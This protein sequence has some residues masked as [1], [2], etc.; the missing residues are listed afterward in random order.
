MGFSKPAC[1]CDKTVL[2]PILQA[3]VV[4]INGTVKSGKANT[5]CYLVC[6]STLP[7]IADILRSNPILCLSF[8]IKSRV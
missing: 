8:L 5:G 4:N 3:S 7:M 2:N 6:S 1:T